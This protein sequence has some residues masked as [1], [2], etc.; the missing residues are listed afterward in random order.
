MSP[1]TPD[2]RGTAQNPDVFFQGRE[3]ANLYYEAVPGK[4]ALAMDQLAARTGRRY[5]LVEYV[6]APD[7]ERVVI[8][9]G[10]ACGALEELVGSM[11]EEGLRVGLLKV[12]LYRPFPAALLVNSLPPT[13]R[14]IAVLDRC[15][16]AGSV[17][18]PLYL[19]VRAAIDEV[20]GSAG[21]EAVFVR[22]PVVIGGRYGL[23]SKELNPAMARAVFDELDKERP[24]QHFTIGIND[25]LS[26]LSLA[27]DPGYELPRPAGEL[28]AVFYGLGADGT[29]GA[30]KN[31]AKIIAS[32]GQYAQGYFVY[33]SKKSG[34]MTVSHLRFGPTPVRSTYLVNGADFVACHQFSLLERVD[35]LGVAKRG[36]K[37]LLNTTWGPDEVWDH[38]SPNVQ[39][40]ILAKELELWVV[41]AGKIAAETK[42]G[43][44]INT[45]MQ[46][47]FFALSEV[48][49]VATAI[50]K[51]KAAVDKT[52]AKRG[53]VVVERNFA[54][55]DAA[56][57]GLARATVPD[58]DLT[59]ISEVAYGAADDR[60]CTR[61]R[62]GQRVHAAGYAV[63]HRRGRRQPS[64]VAAPGGR[65][66]PD[67]HVETRKAPSCRRDPGLGPRALHGLRQVCRCLPAC[68]APN[69]G[70]CP[71]DA[72]DYGGRRAGRLPVQAVPLEGSRR[73][74]AVHPGLPRRLHRM[75]AVCRG[76]PGQVESRP[77]APVH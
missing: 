66:L 39:R 1:D 11:V 8:A 40:Q 18:E 3:A 51:I 2:V 21:S 52:Y 6:G 59:G 34:A 31:S 65:P 69:E 62:G 56:L 71:R 49:P 7:A 25:D 26:H 64:G 47:C 77:G 54:A 41:D 22:S 36:G 14:A 70:I 73:P 33:D 27:W 17:G 19:D 37:F 13:T 42:L 58:E 48:M 29:V 44:R 53:P 28:Q 30:N 4:V 57:S 24:K 32:T 23:S 46:V 43:T 55:I 63:A 67:G 12:R 45:V 76:L 16:E 72:R 5:G 15:K 60:G 50:D 68:R 75:P 61:R 35:I 38:L 9:M 20:I 74:L 10:S